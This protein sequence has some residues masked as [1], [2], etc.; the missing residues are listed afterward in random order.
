[1]SLQSR[2]S[3]TTSSTRMEVSRECRAANESKPIWLFSTHLG[4]LVNISGLQDRRWMRLCVPLAPPTPTASVP[5]GMLQWKEILDQSLPNP[6]RWFEAAGKP[7]FVARR[8]SR[9]CPLADSLWAEPKGILRMGLANPEA[10][11]SSRSSETEDVGPEGILAS[12]AAGW[13]GC[14]AGRIDHYTVYVSHHA[15]HLKLIHCCVSI[16]SQK[17]LTSE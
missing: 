5:C 9:C 4:T 8:R 15:G 3:R 12:R 7:T 16:I 1:M 14:R 13:M 11:F 2:T 6:Y 10:E 17:N